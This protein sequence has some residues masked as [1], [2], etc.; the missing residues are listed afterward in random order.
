MARKMI[1]F[2]NFF[3]KNAS[4]GNFLTFKWQFS[5]GSDTQVNLYNT[6]TVVTKSVNI[7][8]NSVDLSHLCFANFTHTPL[9]HDYYFFQKEV[10][11]YRCSDFLC[12]HS[13]HNLFVIIPRNSSFNYHNLPKL[14]RT[15]SKL[16]KRLNLFV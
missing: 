7:N 13:N 11:Y 14:S 10:I 5:G 12:F 9:S 1:I 15:A 2:G 6:N 8:F 16:Q 3:E 4:F